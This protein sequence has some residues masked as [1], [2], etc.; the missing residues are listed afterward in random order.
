MLMVKNALFNN[1]NIARATAEKQVSDFL[2]QDPPHFLEYAAT[3]LANE[4]SDSQLRQGCGTLLVRAL[5]MA[6]IFYFTF[7][8][9]RIIIK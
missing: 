7:N 9:T 2:I 8:L 3:I 5:R 1:D 6:V 4:A